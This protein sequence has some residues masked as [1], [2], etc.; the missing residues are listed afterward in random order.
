[1]VM[2]PW[3]TFE[4][5]ATVPESHS[6]QF[7]CSARLRH[8]ITHQGN[9]F[10]SRLLGHAPQLQIA[11]AGM[12]PNPCRHQ[13]G[14]MRS[15]ITLT[16]STRKDATAAAISVYVDRELIAQLQPGDNMHISRTACAC[17]GLSIVRDGKMLAAIGAVSAVDLGD[18]F[19]V[20]SPYQLV[21]Q[22]ERVFQEE[23]PEFRFSE[24]PVE[25]IHRT[26]RRILF[27]GECRI[28]Q[29]E[30]R[31]RHGFLSGIPGVDESAAIYL[32]QDRVPAFVNASAELLENDPGELVPWPD[33]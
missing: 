24:A 25:F 7:Q 4:Y 28:G 3:D 6:G 23:D 21:Q 27:R 31:L 1:M 30:I 17:L 26:H 13:P 32:G 9:E 8:P 14:V 2:P 11:D 19:Q 29:Y 22:A 12:T 10:D 20:L 33:E 5:V 16:A 15:R 18:D